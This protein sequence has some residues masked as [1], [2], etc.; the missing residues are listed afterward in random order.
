MVQRKGVRLIVMNS[1]KIEW[2]E[3]NSFFDTTRFQY[4]LA[5]EFSKHIGN[6]PKNWAQMF[7]NENHPCSYTFSY[8]WKYA[9]F[10]LNHP[11]DRSLVSMVWREGSPY[12][13]IIVIMIWGYRK[14][15]NIQDEWFDD[16]IALK[17][18]WHYLLIERDMWIFFHQEKQNLKYELEFE[19]LKSKFDK[20]YHYILNGYW[21]LYDEIEQL[22]QDVNYL[23]KHAYGLNIALWIYRHPVWEIGK[24]A[25]EIVINRLRVKEMR[26]ETI[27]WLLVNWES[28]EFYA[29]GEVIFE[30]K[31]YVDVEDFFNLVR[32]LIH[33]NNSQIRGSFISDLIVYLEGVLDKEFNEIICNDFLPSMILKASDIWEVQELIRLLK[34][35]M[36]SGTLTEVQSLEY[37]TKL[38]IARDIDNALHLDYNEFWKQ[39]EINN[40]IIR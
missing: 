1:G 31:A 9:H 11:I 23:W 4:E 30:L 8:V 25:N 29:L 2:D 17:N 40:G 26:D 14:L 15:N 24:I 33:T 39:A 20:C 5:L 35:L 37:I 7:L 6:L 32:K 12:Q 10:N 22:T 34:F 18:D 3:L 27:S 13:R 21:S 19:Y 28:E 36:H 38:E 16:L